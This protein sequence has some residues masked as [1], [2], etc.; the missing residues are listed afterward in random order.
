[1]CGVRSRDNT[2]RA[3]S[4]RS[5]RWRHRRGEKILPGNK[6]SVRAKRRAGTLAGRGAERRGTE[7]GEGEEAGR[8]ERVACSRI[9]S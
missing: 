6:L 2:D 1:M 7:G 9:E 3:K 4:G 5:C 8:V